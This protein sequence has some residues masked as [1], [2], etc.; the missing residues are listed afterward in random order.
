MSIVFTCLAEITQQFQ[1][2]LHP[3]LDARDLAGAKSGTADENHGYT[4]RL[5]ANVFS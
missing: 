2:A 1:T 5:A 4:Q 3:S